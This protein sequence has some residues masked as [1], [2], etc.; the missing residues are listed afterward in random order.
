[1]FDYDDV[2]V[3]DTS[4]DSVDSTNNPS[5]YSV[6]YSNTT[7]RHSFSFQEYLAFSFYFPF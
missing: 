6:D 5:S 1:M 7:A 3:D 2:E 4:D